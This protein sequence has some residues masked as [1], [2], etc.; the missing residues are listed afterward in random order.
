MLLAMQ[1]QMKILI[2]FLR[3]LLLPVLLINTTTVLAN[4][5]DQEKLNEVAICITVAAHQYHLDPLVLL[6]VKYVESSN[7]L[8]IAPRQNSNGTWDF[9]L[10][11]INTVWETVLSKN[12]I[13]RADLEDPCKNIAVGAWILAEK[14]DRYGLWEGVGRYHSNTPHLLQRYRDKVKAVWEELKIKQSYLQ[15]I[16]RYTEWG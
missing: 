8:D 4:I 9:G 7:K 1:I 15:D 13:N 2:Q 16:N 10:M 6:A 3:Y 5:N 11:Q 14:I 12:G